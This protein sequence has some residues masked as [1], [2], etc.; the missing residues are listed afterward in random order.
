M[1]VDFRRWANLLE[2]ALVDHRDPV[3]EGERLGLVVSYVDDRQVQSLVQRM[4][5]FT[6]LLAQLNVQVGQRLVQQQEIR[7][8]DD[9]ARQC[10]ALLLTAG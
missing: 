6:H 2:L 5:L 9:G 7:R 4:Q 10:D 1:F 8:V 3:R